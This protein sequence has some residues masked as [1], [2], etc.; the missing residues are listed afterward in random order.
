MATSSRANTLILYPVCVL[1]DLSQGAPLLLESS[2][3]SLRRCTHG[4]APTSGC[5]IRWNW[6]ES[7]RLYFSQVPS[8]TDTASQEWGQHLENHCFVMGRD[9]LGQGACVFSAL[10]RNVGPPSQVVSLYSCQRYVSVF[11]FSY[12]LAHVCYCQTSIFAKMASVEVVF[13]CGLNLHFLIA[14]NL[15]T[16]GPFGFHFL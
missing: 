11:L 15:S 3:P 12:N 5:L 14:M 8:R 6:V 7:E 9:L 2:L 13:H 10:E 4:G 16:N 1:T